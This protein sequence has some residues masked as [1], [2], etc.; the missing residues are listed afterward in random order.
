MSKAKVKADTNGGPGYGLSQNSP[1]QSGS[2]MTAR[3]DSLPAG[4]PMAIHE[5]NKH[6]PE[7]KEALMIRPY[8]LD[9][10]TQKFDPKY[11]TL[12]TLLE[13]DVYPQIN[14]ALAAEGDEEPL[15]PEMIETDPAEGEPAMEVVPGEPESME[16][17]EAEKAAGLAKL[18]VESP[19]EF[20][21]KYKGKIQELA[22]EHGIGD[23]IAYSFRSKKI[24]L[25][26]SD[27]ILLLDYDMNP[28]HTRPMYPVEEGM[29]AE[30]MEE[31]E[32]E[33]EEEES[34]E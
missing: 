12:S 26:G 30:P 16:D 9:M 25:I 33:T 4:A 1:F 22:E 14:K 24:E 31:E 23:A 17:K 15:E 13:Q 5:Q 3:E 32:E 18:G 11:P 21:T 8:Y 7:I 34:E 19:E 27:A 6:P 10:K 20:A 29:V 28:L 2:D